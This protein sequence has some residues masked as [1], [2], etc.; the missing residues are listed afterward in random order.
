MTT[1]T[2]INGAT[3]GVTASPYS[4][5]TKWTLAANSIAVCLQVSLTPTVVEP[6]AVRVW[7]ARTADNI[8]ANAA[9]VENLRRGESANFIETAFNLPANIAHIESSEMEPALG[10]YVLVW[11]EESVLGGSATLTVKGTEN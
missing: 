9:A 2:L 6:K 7:W 10:G 4:N 8:T 3:V 11:V 1:T 5:I